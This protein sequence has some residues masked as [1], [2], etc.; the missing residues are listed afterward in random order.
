MILV[1]LDR[2][3]SKNCF[4]ALVSF[5]QDNFP[6]LVYKTTNSES[7]IADLEK[8]SVLFIPGGADRFYCQK[9]N[10]NKNGAIRSFVE[11][12]GIYIGICAGA[13]YACSS[14][15]FIGKD[16]TIHETR[17][18]NFFDGKAIG[19]IPEFTH[20]HFF[21]EHSNAKAVVK[22]TNG[23]DYYYHGG[24]Y[25]KGTKNN[26][27]MMIHYQQSMKPA[28]VSGKYGKGTFLLSGVHFEVTQ[29]RYQNFNFEKA[30]V[31]HEIE[32]SLIRNLPNQDQKQLLH[33]LK[34]LFQV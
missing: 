18:L 8:A 23:A 24:C 17:E 19:S 7:I 14:I 34:N 32:S 21:S 11:C 1:Y 20:G 9:L 26:E 31:D 28:I 13:Y 16:Y 25:F 4:H 22:L 15:E 3:V 5:I 12:G 6:S 10:G 2:G 33:I 30:F 29:K 27:H